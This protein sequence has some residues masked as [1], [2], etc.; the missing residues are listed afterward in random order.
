MRRGIIQ[1]N[2]FKRGGARLFMPGPPKG[3]YF[4]LWWDRPTGVL[5]TEFEPRVDREPDAAGR[6]RYLST[7]IEVPFDDEALAA[8]LWAAVPD[9]VRAR[10]IASEMRRA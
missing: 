8:R 3:R 9:N 4:D 6:L 1:F 5:V 2:G 7:W 10:M